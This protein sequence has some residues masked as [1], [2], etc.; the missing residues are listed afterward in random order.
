MP[1][2]NNS[3]ESCKD[4]KSRNL[5]TLYLHVG[6]HKTGTTSLQG[7]LA[8]CADDL[9]RFD[10][11]YPLSGRNSDHTDLACYRLAHYN[12]AWQINGDPRFAAR[13]GTTENLRT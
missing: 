2:Y 7:L 11:L 5:R 12:L 3:A 1:A 6:I 8:G 9:Q 13:R 10:V 4:K